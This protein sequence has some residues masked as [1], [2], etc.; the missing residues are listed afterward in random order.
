MY[1]RVEVVIEHSE[2]SYDTFSET[3]EDFYEAKRYVKRVDAGDP[4][5]TVKIYI[6]DVLWR[7]YKV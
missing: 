6:D 3:F 2:D 4:G 7:E 1:Y 5:D